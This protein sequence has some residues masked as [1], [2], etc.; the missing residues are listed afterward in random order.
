[1]TQSAVS[2]QVAQL[3]DMLLHPLFSRIRKR[4]KLTPAGEMYL[5]EVRKILNQ[6][7][8]SSRYIQSYGGNTEVLTVISP[9][10]FAAKWLI[11][12]LVG[13]GRKFPNIH[14]DILSDLDSSKPLNNKADVD[15]FSGAGSRPGAISHHLFDERL[16]AVCA[17]ELINSGSPKTLQQLES[18]RLLQLN[19]RPRAWHDWFE[20][21]NWA[22]KES[23]HGPRFETFHMLISAACCGCGVALLPDFLIEDE[24]RQKKLKMA[25]DFEHDIERSYYMSYAEHMEVVPKVQALVQWIQNQKKS[26]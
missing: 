3:E 5:I 7:D 21:Q 10:T 14:L 22:S 19:S 20:A 6:V 23:Y 25:W 17:P 26:E 18:L 13:F 4:L 9:P 2:K 16:V 8:M 15:F 12:R 1:M 24:L 11:P